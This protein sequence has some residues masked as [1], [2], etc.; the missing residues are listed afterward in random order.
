[1]LYDLTVS[2][3]SS[4]LSVQRGRRHGAEKAATATLFNSQVGVPLCSDGLPSLR[5]P[6]GG[7]VNRNANSGELCE[8][9]GLES[10]ACDGDGGVVANIEQLNMRW[11]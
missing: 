11:C 9:W 4:V 8:K 7:R 10:G 6:G 5:I 1:M 3:A 2:P